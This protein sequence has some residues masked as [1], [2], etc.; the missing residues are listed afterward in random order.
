VL[1]SNEK[2]PDKN[3]RVVTRG[4]SIPQQK[5][6]VPAGSASMRRTFFPYSDD[7]TAMEWAEVVFPT[8][9]AVFATTMHFMI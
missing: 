4:F 7:A 2:D 8:P 3:S 9:P 6:K 1:A 5:V